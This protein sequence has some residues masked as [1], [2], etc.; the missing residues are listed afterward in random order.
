L[1]AFAKVAWLL[2]VAIAVM[3]IRV[4]IQNIIHLP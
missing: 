2:L 1:R 3:M 4:G